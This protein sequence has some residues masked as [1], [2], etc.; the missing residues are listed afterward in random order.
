MSVK[1]F[2]A[3]ACAALLL[4]SAS[5]LSAC[6]GVQN[7]IK[8]TV[9]LWRGTS[10]AEKEF[11]E[12]CK[13]AFEDK[14]PQYEVVSS[15]YLYSDDTVV[16]KFA[17][18]QLPAVFEVDASSV[19]RAY[20]N[21]FVRD[22]TAYMKQYGW[23][24]KADG[25]F[26]SEISSGEVTCGVPAEQYSAGMVLN[27]PLLHE[28]G[29]IGKGADG[30]YILYENGSAVYPDTFEKVA[31]AAR[32]VR[33]KSRAYG[34][35]LPSG[36]GE[37]GKIYADIIYNFGCDRLEYGDGDGKWKLSPPDGGVGDAMRWV[38]QMAQE[39]CVDSS[40]AYGVDDWAAK[41]AG[42]EVAMAFCYSS[43]LTA[44]LTAEPSL[45]GNIA[46]VPLPTVR[47]SAVAVWN[48][49]VYAV[50]TS[51]SDEQAKGVFEFLKFFGYG[52]DTDGQ[53]TYYTEKRIRENY[54]KGV[55]VFP[56]LSGWKDGEYNAAMR[57]LYGRYANTE[58]E[59]FS[60]FFDGFDAR[61]R[62]GEPY[63]RDE[64]HILLDELFGIMLFEPTTSNLVTLL[65]ES[66]QRF[67]ERYLKDI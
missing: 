33:A 62:S 39:G 19:G 54:A 42:G 64:L 17:S 67:T 1:K 3:A 27:L 25:Y 15:P 30:K 34:L 37:N 28:A 32:A 48:G 29:V 5:A 49:K 53:S 55:S 16:A 31:R 9:G 8:I 20:S 59:Y 66:E 47:E 12:E 51:A 60:V 57:V 24:E 40:F 58:D 52:P 11:Y 4:L 61:K 44:A 26:L 10:A 63:A 41:M 23:Y 38:K 36:D 14:F 6:G 56:P 43:S 13:I 2:T 18:G 65:A 46:F 35:F 7:R 22:V 21:G 50:S 45:N